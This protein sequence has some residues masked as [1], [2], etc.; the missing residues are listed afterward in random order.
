MRIASGRPGTCLGAFKLAHLLFAVLQLLLHVYLAGA[1]DTDFH[2]ADGSITKWIHCKE[3]GNSMD[4]YFNPDDIAYAVELGA[5]TSKK[6][7]GV[8]PVYKHK[9]DI[10]PA[11]PPSELQQESR[12]QR[13]SRSDSVARRSEATARDLV[14][15]PIVND[16]VSPGWYHTTGTIKNAWIENPQHTLTVYGVA[17][18]YEPPTKP[19]V[20]AC[21]FHPDDK[22]ENC[23][24]E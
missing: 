1:A 12:L 15:K 4:I 7:H 2:C 13:R 6:S 8:C 18:Q 5:W 23:R 24:C 22:L 20:Y 11:I 16:K 3:K 19:K 21:S 17:R 9:R 14:V 10:T